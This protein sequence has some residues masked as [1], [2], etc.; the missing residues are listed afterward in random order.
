MNPS[1]AI[2]QHLPADRG[3]PCWELV[4]LFGSPEAAKTAAVLAHARHPGELFAVM[5]VTDAGP[6]EPPPLEV[7]RAHALA[8]VRPEVRHLERCLHADD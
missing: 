3:G 7:L 8:M 4:G 6:I 1:H 5:R 2:W